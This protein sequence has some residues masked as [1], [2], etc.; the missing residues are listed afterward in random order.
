MITLVRIY[1]YKHDMLTIISM[2]SYFG[3]THKKF[4]SRLVD[5]NCLKCSTKVHFILQIIVTT[6]QNKDSEVHQSKISIKLEEL[7]LLKKRRKKNNHIPDVF[8]PIYNTKLSIRKLQ[9]TT[10]N[11]NRVEVIHMKK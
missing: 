3:T 6:K 9:W 7:F 5:N 4:K 11:D 10:S 1:L 8:S 2:T